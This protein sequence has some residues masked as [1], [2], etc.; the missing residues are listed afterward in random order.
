VNSLSMN[1]WPHTLIVFVYQCVFPTMGHATTTRGV[2]PN[3]SIT[4]D[5]N[6]MEVDILG[7]P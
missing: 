7:D 1:L 3:I 2:V 5:I 4:M 6:D